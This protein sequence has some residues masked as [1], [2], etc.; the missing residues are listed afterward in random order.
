MARRPKQK[1]M[2][3]ITDARTK[4]VAFSKRRHSIFKK[5]LDLCTL[6]AVEMAIIVFSPGG[7]AYSFGNPSTEAVLN[8]FIAAGFSA[9]LMMIRRRNSSSDEEERARQEATM[10][11]LNRQYSDLS[12]QLK[13]EKKREKELKKKMKN[14]PDI[15]K[16]NRDELMKMKEWLEDLRVKVQNREEEMLAAQTTMDDD[17]RLTLGGVYSAGDQACSSSVKTHRG[18]A[19]DE[20]FSANMDDGDLSLSLSAFVPK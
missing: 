8:R 12:A 7:K 15:E 6:C 17:L 10:A 5:A 9:N 16:M 3:L 11:E 20:D 2:T 4:Q 1:N 13:E 14:L 19:G 18:E